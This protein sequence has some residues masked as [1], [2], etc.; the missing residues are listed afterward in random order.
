MQ[1]PGISGIDGR[2]SPGVR[3]GESRLDLSVVEAPRVQVAV[4]AANDRSPAIGGGAVEAEATLLNLLGYA[5]PLLL[6]SAAGKGLREV[7][8][9]Y[10]A[11]I[12]PKDLRL[13]LRGEYSRSWIVEEPF[14]I[15]DIRSRS[16]TLEGG[17]V[18]PLYE[19]VGE[20]ITMGALLSR[21]R[22]ETFLLGRRFP[23]SPGTENGICD[24]TALRFTQEW[25]KRAQNQVITVRSIV[26]LGIDALGATNNVAE[27]DSQFVT[28]LGQAQWIRQLR[29]AGD[30]I[31]VR[32]DL[33]LASDALLPI[34]Q[35][36]VGGADTVRGYR[37]SLLV[38]DNGFIS[39][40]E[41]RWPLLRLPVPALGGRPEDGLVQLAPFVDF[42]ATWNH[43]QDSETRTIA[44]AGIGVRWQP[45]PNIG[46]ELY[47]GI[48]LR[49]V[50]DPRDQGLQDRGIHFQ[51]RVGF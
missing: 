20:S 45:A 43:G 8:A 29:E 21:R 26:S 46:A 35:L 22:S 31:V 34:E 25:I 19:G 11:P 27:P 7:E 38:R 4:R 28:W 9:A 36:G 47:W 51:L 33:Q 24:V 5:D 48:G 1:G 40:I 39:S 3:P 2:V 6:R 15:L 10:S 42:G 12:T 13:H 14:T 30:Q 16:W 32:A 37:E 49:D 18:Y 23:F 50:D 41:Y 44:S 17:V